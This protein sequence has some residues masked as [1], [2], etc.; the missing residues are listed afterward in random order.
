M[1]QRII[2]DKKNVKS[3]AHPLFCSLYL[4]CAGV[5][6]PTLGLLLPLRVCKRLSLQSR[7]EVWRRLDRVI[8]KW[9]AF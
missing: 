9:S 5:E 4:V 8:K 2:P 7:I 1:P 6:L 3:A